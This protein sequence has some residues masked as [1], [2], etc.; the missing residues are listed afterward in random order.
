LMVLVG[1]GEDRTATNRRKAWSWRKEDT[2]MNA[3]DSTSLKRENWF[4]DIISKG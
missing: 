3:G 1:A 2:W 4:W